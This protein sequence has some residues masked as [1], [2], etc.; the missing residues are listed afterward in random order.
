[1]FMDPT[2]TVSCGLPPGWAFDPRCSSLQTL[3][4]LGC[5]SPASHRVFVTVSPRG[6]LAAKTDN[7]WEAC[8]HAKLPPRVVRFEGRHGP[9]V[10]AE[11]APPEQQ[12]GSRLAWLRGPRLDA[13]VEH[14]GV[15]LGS[16][17]ET[18][19]IAEFRR[20]LDVPVNRRFG[21]AGTR[22]DWRGGQ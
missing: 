14:Q 3:A 17:L 19:E 21:A 16:A 13:I 18:S 11:P 15:P 9:M 2:G 20:T 12:L 1:M 4:F 10:I 5:N 8:V 7:E 22:A 6:I